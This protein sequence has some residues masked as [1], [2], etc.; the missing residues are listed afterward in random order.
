MKNTILTLALVAMTTTAAQADTRREECAWRK[1]L[2]YLAQ[3]SGLPTNNT[4]AIEAAFTKQ[5]PDRM[6]R[7]R[8]SLRRLIAAL[9]EHQYR[10]GLSDSEVVTYIK[11]DALKSASNTGENTLWDLANCW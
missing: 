2:S 1:A 4:E 10:N 5:Y 6:N 8:K 11:L 9:G 7:A 3:Q